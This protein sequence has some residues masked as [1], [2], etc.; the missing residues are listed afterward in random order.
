MRKSKSF[1]IILALLFGWSG[2]DRFYLGYFGVGLLKL[3]TF[4]ALGIFWIV[5]LIFIAIGRLEPKNGAFR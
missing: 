2:A 3:C 5:D 4:G 1:A